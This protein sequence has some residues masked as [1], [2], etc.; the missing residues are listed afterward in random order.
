MNAKRHGHNSARV[1]CF[2]FWI[3]RGVIT[4][5]FLWMLFQVKRQDCELFSQRID[6]SRIRIGGWSVK[7]FGR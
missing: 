1:P 5:R 3:G 7:L 6:R 4:T 2:G